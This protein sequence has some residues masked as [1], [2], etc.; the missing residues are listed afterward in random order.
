M[1]LIRIFISSKERRG[2]CWTRPAPAS[3]KIDPNIDRVSVW[4]IAPKG[5]CTWWV[6]RNAWLV[7]ADLVVKFS[8]TLIIP[9]FITSM[10][11]IK[12]SH[13]QVWDWIISMHHPIVGAT[14]EET[15]DMITERLISS[16]RRTIRIEPKLVGRVQLLFHIYSC[17]GWECSPKGM[18][19]EEDRSRGVCFEKSLYRCNK[20]ISD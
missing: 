4:V 5:V 2:V 12:L 13:R 7:Q 16:A 3:S 19:C 1:I 14:W 10:V 15:H 17:E 8:A 18:P 9:N 20:L 6:L 11:E